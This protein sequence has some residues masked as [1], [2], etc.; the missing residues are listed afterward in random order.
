MRA[1]FTHSGLLNPYYKSEG[2]SVCYLDSLI[3]RILLTY[4]PLFFPQKEYECMNDEQE[5]L[6][7]RLAG[8]GY[9]A[10]RKVCFACSNVVIL[11]CDKVHAL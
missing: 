1:L 7:K 8:V 11:H 9:T 5:Q 6:H 3:D 10:F 2:M 4:D